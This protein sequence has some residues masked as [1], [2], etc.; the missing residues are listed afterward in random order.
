MFIGCLQKA[1]EHPE[2]REYLL[3]TGNDILV[4]A[5]KS[6][7]IWGVGI[8]KDDPRIYDQSQWR[9]MNL[10]GEIWMDVRRILQAEVIF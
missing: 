8:A 1:R 7:V 6:D 9:G 10:L 4:E 2:I 5:S 3:S